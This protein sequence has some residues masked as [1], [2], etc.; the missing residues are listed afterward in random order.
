MHIPEPRAG[1]RASPGSVCRAA[2]GL[3]WGTPRTRQCVPD[4][5]TFRR[6]LRAPL[7]REHSSSLAPHLFIV[8]FTFDSFISSKASRVSSSGILCRKAGES[9]CCS[10]HK[11]QCHLQG[12]RSSGTVSLPGLTHGSLLWAVPLS[13]TT[14]SA[15]SCSLPCLGCE[16][17]LHLQ[18]CSSSAI[19]LRITGDQN[20]PPLVENFCKSTT[21]S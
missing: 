2:D 16:C 1:H 21:E 10:V 8:S 12:A 5:V 18:D 11:Q 3:G 6:Q 20:T 9:I 15:L 7:S 17:A 4:P 13:G 19:P 14:S